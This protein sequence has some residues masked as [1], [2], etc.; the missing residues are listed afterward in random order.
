MNPVRA[1]ASF[2]LLAATLAGCASHPGLSAPV[3][4]ALVAPD[5]QVR[6]LETRAEG[7]QIYRCAPTKDD[8][9]RF[10]WHF[11]S[12]EATLYDAA[13]AVVGK[14]YGGPTWQANDGSTVVG[15]VRARAD[16]AEAGSIPQLLLRAKANSGSGQFSAV[17]SVQ[18][19][20]T[21]GGAAPASACTAAQV[22]QVARVPYKALYFFYATR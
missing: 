12:P 6:T 10:E 3:P 22:D 18:R 1:D 17:R 15:E 8:P 19:L 5:D 9:S 21:S 7:V 4:P 13:G 11:E 16:S 2:L 14:H 20:A